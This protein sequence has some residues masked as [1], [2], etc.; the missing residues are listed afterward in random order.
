MARLIPL[1]D[2]KRRDAHVAEEWP[3]RTA[4]HRMAGQGGVEV[5]RERLI[6]GTD[7]AGYEA[8]LRAHENDEGVARALASGVPEIDLRLVGRRLGDAARVYLRKNGAVLSV[9]RVLRVIKGADGAE[10]SRE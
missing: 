9:A 4:S 8:L 1:M 7:T 3:K 2:D 6:R 10:K 5:R